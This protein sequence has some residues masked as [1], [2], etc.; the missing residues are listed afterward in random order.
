MATKA[1]TKQM[2]A[3]SEARKFIT[4]VYCWMS[5]ALFLSGLTAFF[6]STN[7]TLIALLW[8]SKFTIIGV[9]V[10][11]V[12]LVAIITLVI[13]K[14]SVIT[15]SVLF[16]FYAIVNGLSLSSVFIV[17]RLSSITAIF[18]ISAGMFVC[19]SIFGAVTKSRINS[20]YRYFVMTFFGLIIAALVNLVLKLDIISMIISAISVFLFMGLTAVET[21]KVLKV[22]QLADSSD[23]FKKAAIYG[24]LELYIDFI[25]I[26]LNLL[27]LFGREQD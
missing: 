2:A 9:L 13:E 15:A 10:F 26:F 1:L 3:S 18:M 8:K 14:V 17:F 23:K 19:M 5:L 21:Q 27:K 11:E 25:G 16:I 6:V 7:E 4:S 24:A 20:F 22:S 12:L